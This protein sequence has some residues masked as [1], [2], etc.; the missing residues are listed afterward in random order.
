MGMVGALFGLVLTVRMLPGT[1]SSLLTGLLADTFGLRVVF[2]LGLLL[3][4]P[5]LAVGAVL[6]GTRK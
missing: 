1:F 3:A 2:G 5:V 6:G 4:L